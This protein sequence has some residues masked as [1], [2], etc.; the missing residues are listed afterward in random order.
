MKEK[1]IIQSVKPNHPVLEAK[2]I[3]NSVDKYM[4]ILNN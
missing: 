4:E 1:T 2:R 3:L